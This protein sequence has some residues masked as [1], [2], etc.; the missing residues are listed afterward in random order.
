MKRLVYAEDV[1]SITFV[2]N[3]IGA[4]LVPNEMGKHNYCIY[5]KALQ[6]NG[7]PAASAL[8]GKKTICHAS[9]Y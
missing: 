7:I 8:C 3:T 4:F 6:D 1:K 2:D 9:T 5:F